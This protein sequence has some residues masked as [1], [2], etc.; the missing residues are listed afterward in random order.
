MVNSELI[1]ELQILN[2]ELFKLYILK[3]F[4]GIA[5]N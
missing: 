2:D 1:N 4:C 5:N 3:H